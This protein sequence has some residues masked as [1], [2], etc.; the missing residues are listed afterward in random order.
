M[1]AQKVCLSLPLLSANHISY[2]K[3]LTPEI[4]RTITCF[5][6]SKVYSGRL[7][8]KLGGG[9]EIGQDGYVMV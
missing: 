9:N 5:F 3:V 2:F 4:H 7:H 1:L 8:Q 6:I